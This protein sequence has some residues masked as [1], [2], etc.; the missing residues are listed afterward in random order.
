MGKYFGTDGFRGEVGRTLTAAH[1]FRIGSFLGHYFGK[2]HKARVVIGKDP[3][4]SSYTLEYALVAGLTASGADA[5]ILHV[6]PTPAV[7]YVTRADRFDCGIMI[8]ASHNPYC[9][10]G[11]KLFDSKGE[12]MDEKTIDALEAYQAGEKSPTEVTLKM[13]ETMA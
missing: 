3:R 10:N 12:K 6:I 1:A 8:S 13:L 5:Y 4:R 7:S 2:E 11:I 9:D